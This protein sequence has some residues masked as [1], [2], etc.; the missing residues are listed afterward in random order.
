MLMVLRR[1][2]MGNDW[3]G[4]KPA[5]PGGTPRVHRDQVIAAADRAGVQVKRASPITGLTTAGWSMWW[6]L[7]PNDVWRTLATTNHQALKELEELARKA[8]P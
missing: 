7:R 1:H 2:S 4:R 8:P 5:I 6:V 3:G